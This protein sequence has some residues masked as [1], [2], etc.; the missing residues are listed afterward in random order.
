MSCLGC[1][2]KHPAGASDVSERKTECLSAH[3]EAALAKELVPCA[4]GHLDDA[5]ELRHLLRRVV[6]DVG[7]AL[8]GVRTIC[9][10]LY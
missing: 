7:D 5:G 2:S 10:R 1:R 4:E 9:M 8:E 6:L 3:L